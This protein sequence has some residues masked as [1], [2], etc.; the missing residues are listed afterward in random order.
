MRAVWSTRGKRCGF[1]TGPG[2]L[3]LFPDLQP[4]ILFPDAD[5]IRRVIV[6]NARGH[7]Y[8]EI[9]EPLLEDPDHVAFLPLKQMNSEQ[10]NAFEVNGTGAN[11]PVWPEVGSRMMVRLLEGNAMLGCWITVEPGRY[12]YSIDWSGAVTVKTVIW[13]YLATEVCWNG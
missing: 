11:L 4:F 6:K 3:L 8:H 1:A 5:K 10:R 9:G 7:V 2:Q 12:R 13:E